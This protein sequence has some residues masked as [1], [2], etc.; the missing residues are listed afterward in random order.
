MPCF[1]DLCVVYGTDIHFVFEADLY[2]MDY[3]IDNMAKQFV[4]SIE[5]VEGIDTHNKACNMHYNRNSH[6][7]I[8]EGNES[9]LEHCCFQCSPHYQKFLLLQISSIIKE[10][11]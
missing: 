6:N 11:A 3:H 5:L 10:L 8:Q 7:Y 2:N 9:C 1:E 4:D